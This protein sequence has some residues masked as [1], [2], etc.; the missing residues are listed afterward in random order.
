[1]KPND[2][3]LD[4]LLELQNLDRVARSGYQLRGVSRPESVAEHGWHLAFL[5]WALA[6]EVEGVDVGRALELALVHD[7]AEVRTGD[8]PMTAARYLPAGTKAAAERAAFAELM[9]PCGER[10]RDRFAEY[11]AQTTA[12]ARLVKACDKLQLL[13]KVA[14]YQSWGEGALDEFWRHRGNFPSDEFPAVAELA[15][16]LEERF[17]GAS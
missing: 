14:T 8:L 6:P 16:R 10:A 17:G 2:D 4:T 13:L 12:E 7:V 11:Q 9:A 3:L 15:A 1:M 5:I